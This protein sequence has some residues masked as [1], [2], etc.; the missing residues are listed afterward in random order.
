MFNWFNKNLFNQVLTGAIILETGL[1]AALLKFGCTPL[2][3]DT[4]LVCNAGTLPAWV[5]AW[6]LP[7][8]VGA[9]AAQGAVKWGIK[10][11]EGDTWLSAFFKPTAVISSS[12]APGTATQHQVDTGPRK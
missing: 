5:P 11:F 2:A 7:W 4:A 8:L 12:G 3:A 6:L 10:L 9:A 1:S